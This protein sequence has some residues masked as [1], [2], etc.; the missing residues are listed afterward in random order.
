MSTVFAVITALSTAKETMPSSLP[1]CSRHALV[2]GTSYE[3]SG[4]QLEWTHND[5]NNVASVLKDIGFEVVKYLDLGLADMKEAYHK[6]ADK[7]EP[8]I[9]LVYFSGHAVR[10]NGQNFLLPQDIDETEARNI[11]QLTDE[12]FFED[13]LLAKAFRLDFFVRKLRQMGCLPILVLDASRMTAL[14]EGASGVCEN[15]VRGRASSQH[16]VFWADATRDGRA[17]LASSPKCADSSPFTCHLVRLLRDPDTSAGVGLTALFHKVAQAVQ[18][19]TQ[20]TQMPTYHNNIKIVTTDEVVLRLRS[21]PDTS[22]HAYINDDWDGEISGDEGYSRFFLNVLVSI[23]AG[24]VPVV[25]YMV[26][27]Y[28]FYRARNRQPAPAPAA[29]APAPPPP[30]REVPAPRALPRA[31]PRTEVSICYI[32]TICTLLYYIVL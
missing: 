14:T 7:V 25:V 24:S 26:Y 22:C 21:A 27:R 4:L 28:M 11:R 32:L 1:N 20:N 13:F 12:D 23:V 8:G 19:D 29:P 17:A 9:A 10:V 31:L 15:V 18:T 3:G 6:F 30:P 16:G 2:F 5:A